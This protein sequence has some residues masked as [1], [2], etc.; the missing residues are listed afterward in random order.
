MAAML[1]DDGSMMMSE[2]APVEVEK[3][4]FPALSAAEAAVSICTLRIV[5]SIYISIIINANVS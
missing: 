2:D 3:P 5:T 1:E 4:N